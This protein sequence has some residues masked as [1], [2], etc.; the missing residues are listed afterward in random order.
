[1][2][3]HLQVTT[4]N[5]YHSAYLTAA[6]YLHTLYIHFSVDWILHVL[7]AGG[8]YVYEVD[9]GDLTIT[10]V[11]GTDVGNYTCVASN[12]VGVASAVVKVLV[13]GELGGA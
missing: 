2:E 9:T 4:T 11:R 5:P 7:S 10:Q 1:M 6:S 8:R 13:R 3:P 12:E